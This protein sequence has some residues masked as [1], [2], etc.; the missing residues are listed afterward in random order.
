MRFYSVYFSLH[1]LP[2]GLLKLSEF[3]SRLNLDSR[4]EDLDLVSIHC[5]ICDQDLGIF[6][7]FRLIDAYSLVEDEPFVQV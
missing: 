3:A 6:Q 2:F 5:S 7:S 4:T 1:L